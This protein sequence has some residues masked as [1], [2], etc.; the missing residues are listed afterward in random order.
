MG[1]NAIMP[2][3]S[4]PQYK[5]QN[6]KNTISNIHKHNVKFILFFVLPVF[7]G[8]FFSAKP[9]LSIWLGNIYNLQILMGL[10]WFFMWLYY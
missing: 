4:E 9:V 3:I 7:C 8:L 5:A 6:I 1:L 10:K 2:K